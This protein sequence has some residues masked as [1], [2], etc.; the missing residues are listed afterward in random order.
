MRPSQRLISNLLLLAF[1]FLPTLLSAQDLGFERS[2]MKSI[3]DTVS[4]DISKNFYDPALNGVDWKAKVAEAREKI[5]KAQTVSQ[6][7]TAIFALVDSLH[8]SHTVFLPPQ[9]AVHTTFEFEAL[10]VGDH[11]FIKKVEK[12]GA[13]E[14]CGLKPGDEIVMLNGYR[15]TRENFSLMM[16]FFRALL[17]VSN[18]QL[19][20]NRPGEGQKQIQ[21]IGTQHMGSIITDLTKI[22]T[23]WQLIREEE[24]EEKFNHYIKP[25]DGVGYVQL[26]EFSHEPDDIDSLLGKTKDSQALIVDLRSN[27]GGSLKTLERMIGHFVAEPTVVAE[28]RGRK[29]P[30]KIQA[31]PAKPNYQVPLFV[32]VDSQSASAAEIFAHHFQRNKRAVIVGDRTSGRVQAANMYSHQVGVDT[33]VPYAVEV[34]IGR[35]IFPDGEELEKRGVTPDVM[36]L[37][38]QEDLAAGRDT[39]LIK[40]QQLASEKLS[41]GAPKPGN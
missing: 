21:L 36:C 31:K 32:L 16:L 22:D 28:I 6:M 10:P 3:L 1:I 20:I 39:C 18:M 29:Q 37:P 25:R 12:K 15:P 27:P 11:I 40:A 19:A 34:S 2:R 4:V 30:E 9:R 8:D 33:I 38:T 35:V 13:A 5:D 17:P 26:V 41:A 14:K 23:I 24:N 7:I